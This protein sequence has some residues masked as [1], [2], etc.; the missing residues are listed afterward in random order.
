VYFIT[1]KKILKALPVS[2]LRYLEKMAPSSLD[3]ENS[4]KIM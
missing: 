1:T 2:S 4:T 3:P